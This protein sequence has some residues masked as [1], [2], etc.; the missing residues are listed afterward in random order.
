VARDLIATYLA[1]LGAGLPDSPAAGLALAEVEDGLRS[2]AED[3]VLRGVEPRRAAEL[4]VAEFG[5]PAEVAAEFVPVLAAAAAHRNGL[6]LLA[7]GP[8]IGA[9]WLASAVLAWRAAPVAVAAGIAV[10]VAALVAAV[11]RVAYGVAMTGRLGRRFGASPASAVRAVAG[12]ARTAVALDALLVLVALP[13]LVLLG[14][15]APSAA[16]ALAAALLSLGRLT[17]ARR[18]VRRLDRSLAAMS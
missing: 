18:V 14:R 17:V 5:D 7:T 4:A 8:M 6:A 9:L 16:L 3:H 2:A 10:A 13:G 1:H 15:S 11:P 12:A